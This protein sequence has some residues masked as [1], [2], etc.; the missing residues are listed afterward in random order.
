MPGAASA[1]PVTWLEVTRAVAVEVFRSS[2]GFCWHTY[3]R[4]KHVP[5]AR[6]VAVEVFRS[7]DGLCRPEV[8]PRI[9]GLEDDTEESTSAC[10]LSDAGRAM[11]GHPTLLP[12]SNMLWHHAH[13]VK[14]PT[15]A[16]E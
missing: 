15:S 3:L 13:L 11:P 5:T 7:S 16:I 6:A 10:P 2:D 14:F 4:A 8:H 12:L 9:P 1:I